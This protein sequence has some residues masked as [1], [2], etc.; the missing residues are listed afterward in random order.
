[1]L[2]AELLGEL[3]DGEISV[4]T[5][6]LAGRCELSRHGACI[7][8][9]LTSGT[10]IRLDGERY[11]AEPF[12][13]AVINDDHA[14]VPHEQWPPGLSLGVH[15]IVGRPF[16]CIRGTA[17]YHL[18]PSHLDDRWDLHRGHIQLV[19]LLGHLL[20]KAGA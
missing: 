8:A 17:E 10:T 2:H 19:D 12:A 7:H 1:M 13:V 6:R 14:V 18:H 20:T 9:V 4:A 11:D 5:Q 3:L 15:P 16:A